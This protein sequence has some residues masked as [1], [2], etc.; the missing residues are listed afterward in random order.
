MELLSSFF[1]C[2]VLPAPPRPSRAG[3]WY[4]NRS[5]RMTDQ[6]Q[7]TIARLTE[8][9]KTWALHVQV[10]TEPLDYEGLIMFTAT[11]RGRVTEDKRILVIA[12]VTPDGDVDIRECYGLIKKVLLP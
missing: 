7:K 11:N 3:A 2:M 12:L 5:D 6:Q 4:S 8:A 10:E 9:V 1:N